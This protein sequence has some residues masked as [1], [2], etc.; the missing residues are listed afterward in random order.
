MIHVLRHWW[1]V[2]VLAAITLATATMAQAAEP[3]ESGAAKEASVATVDTLALINGAAVTSADIDA[4]IMQSHQ[5]ADMRRQ[6]D[7]DLRSLLDKAINDELLIQQAEAIGLDEDEAIR[8]ELE[9]SWAGNAVG[10]YLRA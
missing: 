8:R 4:L 2:T 5:S 9:D 3:G 6:T 7:D 1:L 10:A